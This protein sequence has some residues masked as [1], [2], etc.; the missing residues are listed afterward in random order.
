MAETPPDAHTSPVSYL[1]HRVFVFTLLFLVALGFRAFVVGSQPET[2]IAD[3]AD[4]HQLATSVAAGRG[5]VNTAGDPTAWRPPAY[6]AF[7]SLIY[8]ITGPSV[9]SATLVQSFVGALTVLLLMLFA[10]TILSHAETVIAGV[11]A[12]LYPGLV[13]LPRLLLSENLSLLLILITFWAIAM[14][15]TSR[16]LWWLVLFGAVGGLNTLVRGG[17]L[18]LPMMLGAGLLIVALRRGAADWKRT[19]TGLLIAIAAFVV[20]LTPWTVRNYRVFHRFVPVATQEGLTLYGSYWPPTKNGRFIWGTLPGT[21]DANIAAA[22]QLRDE[23]AASKYLQHVTF[24]RL[25]EQPGYFFRVIPSKMIS[26]LVPLDWEIL[27][28]PVG[29]GRKI[30]WVYILI[31]LPALLGLIM[32]WRDRRSNQWLLWMT[33]ILVLVQTIIFY[34]SPRFRLPAE[35]MAILFASVSLAHA[36]GFLKK[37]HALLG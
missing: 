4:Y 20:V 12:A 7:L 31:A 18:V 19:F 34:G 21:E 17:N 36:R 6:P 37:R 29:T 14:Y 23:P 35:L 11:I 3:A 2:P 27:P 13:W 15:L 1:D 30:N 16:R 26:L 5:Y 25:R 9:M 24:E 8:R 10:S 33:P 28:H 32:L 22:N